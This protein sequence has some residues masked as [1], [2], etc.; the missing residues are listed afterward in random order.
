MEIRIER[1]YADSLRTISDLYVNN[2]FFCNILEDADR[3]LDSAMSLEEI[4]KKKV[5]GKTAIPTGKYEVVIS[6]SNRFQKL[7]PLLSGVPGY[8]GI[9]IHPG[10]TEA[11]TEGC[12]LPGTADGLKVVNSRS[13]FSKLFGI[14]KSSL[15]KE[16]VYV[17]ITYSKLFK[18]SLASSH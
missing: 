11:D 10:N 5:H 1:R 13:T 8:S 4:S 7:L 6:Y 18:G 9:R 16:K 3:G 15:A 2:E 12:L 14:I 17:T